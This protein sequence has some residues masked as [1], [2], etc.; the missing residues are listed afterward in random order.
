MELIM[1]DNIRQ[2]GQIS[3]AR[4]DGMEI[5][6]LMRI[7]FTRLTGNVKNAEN[8]CRTGILHK[9]RKQQ[10]YIYCKR[11]KQVFCPPICDG[12]R[13]FLVTVSAAAQN[14]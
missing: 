9:I 2:L 12:N 1:K 3:A 11:A 5:L 6:S 10:F 7:L 8:G 13:Q 4:T 14:K